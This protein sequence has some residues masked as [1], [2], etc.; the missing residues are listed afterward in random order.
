MVDVL[1]QGQEVFVPVEED[2]FVSALKQMADGAVSAVKAQGVAL[3]DA[4]EDLGKRCFACFDQEMDVVTHEDIG[5]EAIGV[6]VFVTGE[7][8][9]MFFVINGIFESLL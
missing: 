8:Q 3:I 9:E 5:I 1:K 4:L 2:G 7:N 6:A